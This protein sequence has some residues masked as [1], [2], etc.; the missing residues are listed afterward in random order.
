MIYAG[1]L[2]SPNECFVG[3]EFILKF[4]MPT[5]FSF[6]TILA[7]LSLYSYYKMPI[8]VISQPKK[9]LPYFRCNQLFHSTRNG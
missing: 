4:L 9:V 6:Q 3:Y 8:R 5:F 1:N 7:A 2:I